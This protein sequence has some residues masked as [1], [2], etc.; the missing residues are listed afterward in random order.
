M[1]RTRFP[2]APCSIARS[3]DVLGDWWT[4]LIIR[5]CLY[6]VRRFDDFHRWLGIARNMLSRRL[7]QLVEQG[8]LERRQY[9]DRPPRYEYTLS[10][11]GYAAANVLVAMMPFGEHW[12]FG[13]EGEP[14]RLYDRAT[15]RRVHPVLVDESTGERIDS[16]RLYAGPGAAFPA[17]EQIR[18][19]RFTEFYER[20][21][22]RR[23][24]Q[25]VSEGA[26]RDASTG[27]RPPTHGD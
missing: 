14:I 17:N 22:R 23:T 24:P 6:G 21:E 18:R 11:K 13:E 25:H 16:R 1:D 19:A 27:P 26:T 10:E 7:A 12:L 8:V 2:E 15:G 5:D 3:L 20:A 9:A 4:P